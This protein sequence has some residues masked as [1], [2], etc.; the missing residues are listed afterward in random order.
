MTQNELDK[1]FEE[2]IEKVRKK[3]SVKGNEYAGSEEDRLI[4]FKDGAET[5][6]ETPAQVCFGYMLKH[7]VSIKHIACRGDARILTVSKMGREI[8]CHLIDE[9][10]GDLIAYSVLLEALLTEQMEQ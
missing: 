3:L 8:L 5:S 9:K 6:G 1:L 2:R 7:F 10:I 4:N